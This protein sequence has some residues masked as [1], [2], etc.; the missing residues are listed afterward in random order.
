VLVSWFK[1]TPRDDVHLD[2]Q[3][4]LEILE[5]TDVI[6]KRSTRL[7]V[8]EQIQV[9]VRTSFAAG[10]GSEHG[11]PMRATLPRDA[12]D[13]R[14]PSAEPFQCQHVFGHPTRVLSFPPHRGGVG[15]KE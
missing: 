11:D 6:K 12:Q 14:A 3:E 2:T 10:N 15:Y 1:R 4:F 7:E 8:H 9:A 13:L 5:Q